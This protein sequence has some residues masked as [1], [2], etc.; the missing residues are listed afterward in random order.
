MS[1]R[2]YPF[3]QTASGD[4]VTAYEITSQDGLRAEVLDFGCILNRL[5]VPDRQGQLADIVLGCDTMDDVM[6]SPHFGS[7][8]GRYGNRIARGHFSLEGNAYQL[9]CNNGNNHLHGGH[10]GLDRRMWRVDAYDPA[11]HSLVF[12][13]TSM[14]GEERYPGTMDIVVSLSLSG[15][16]LTLMYHATTDQP[17]IINLTNHSYFNL[18]GHHSGSILAQQVQID[19][20]TY[21]AVDEE[22]IPVGD[23]PSVASSAFDFRQLRAIGAAMEDGKN[24]PQLQWPACKGGFDHNFVLNKGMGLE[25]AAQACD[26]ASGRRM[27]VITDQPGIQFYT[28]NALSGVKGKEGAIHEK[29]AAFCMETQHAPDSPNHP[30][31][32]SVALLP[33]RDYDSVT[34]YQFST[35]D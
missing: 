10:V 20:D 2:S 30:E 16:S 9:N 33:G 22:L 31:W 28:A 11:G 7:T 19:A 35:I 29:N 17:T 3:G 4:A 13:Y 1:I 8:I 12:H 26:P 21:T 18:A 32:P 27:T 25:W 23:T 5:Y 15:R 34:I 24:H 6:A 14:D